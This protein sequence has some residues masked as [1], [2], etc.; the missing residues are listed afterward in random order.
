MKYTTIF[1]AKYLK[2]S[3]ENTFNT[4]CGMEIIESQN[5]SLVYLDIWFQRIY[6][7]LNQD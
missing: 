3:K 7:S 4:S 5:F 6:T 2:Y 1:Y